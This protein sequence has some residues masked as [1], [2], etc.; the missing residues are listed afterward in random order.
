MK[1]LLDQ[2]SELYSKLKRLIMEERKWS[3][4]KASL[5]FNSENP[6]LGGTTPMGMILVGR[7]DRL[8]KWIRSALDESKSK[9]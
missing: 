9:R 7:G 2:Y 3:E 4:E 6:H 1:N 8:E 5:W